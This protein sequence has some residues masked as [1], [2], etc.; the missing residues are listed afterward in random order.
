MKIVKSIKQLIIPVII[1]IPFYALSQEEK[2]KSDEIYQEAYTDA[3]QDNFFEALRAKGIENYD[4]AIEF[5]M[6]CKKLEPDSVVVDYEL[7]RNYYLMHN[8]PEAENHYTIALQGEPGNKWYLNGLLEVYRAMHDLEKAIEVAGRLT[9]NHGEYFLPLAELYVEKGDYDKA[10]NVIDSYVNKFGDSS[11]SKILR[12]K[13]DRLISYSKFQ[14]AVSEPEEAKS[15]EESPLEK[16]RSKLSSLY[17]SGE[18]AELLKNSSE[19]VDNFPA[20]PE[21]YYYKGVGLRMTGN[22]D[23]AVETLEEGLDYIIEDEELTRKFYEELIAIFKA[24]N[25]QNKL[26]EY[27]NKLKEGRL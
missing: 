13:V 20:Q 12:L 18:Y 23:L 17:G 16:Y 3:F 19:A 9:E 25:N 1:A 2:E 11:E 10:K 27:Q 15:I 26:K 5:L 4:K 22:P 8:Y 6:E 24:L 14:N 21:F 7:A